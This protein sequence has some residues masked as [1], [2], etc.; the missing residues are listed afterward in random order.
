MNLL[1]SFKVI[2]MWLSLSAICGQ[3]YAEQTKPNIVMLY[4]DDWAWNGS[5]V[6]M[7]DAMENS[8]MPVLQMPNVEKLAREGMKFS[9]AYGSPQCAPAR[10][11]LQTGQSAA[12]NGFTVVLGKIKDDYYDM[13]KTYNYM[14]MIPNVAATAL[15]TNSMTI[16]K[17]LKPLGYESAHI[18]KWHMYCDPG[19]AGYVLHDGDTNNNPG[20]T[21]TFNLKKGEKAPSRL[22][23]D[24]KDPKLMF[25]MTEKAIGF[26]EEQVQKKKPFYLQISHYA[27][28]EG[29][30]CLD[31]TRQKYVNH[32]VVQEYYKKMGTT[33][34]KVNRKQD[35]ANWL[36]MG[37]DMDGRIG[38]VLNKIKELGI[39]DNTYVIMVSDNGYR[40]SDVAREQKQPLHGHKWWVWEG[41][42]R[43]PMIIKG[44]GILGGSTF[45]A[46]V[47]N[48]DFLPTF[49]EWAGGS[50]QSLQNIDGISLAPYLAGKTPEVDFVNRNLYFHFP[51]YR[52]SMPHSAV[53]SGKHKVMHF[54][55]RPDIPM[56]FDLSV[57]PGEVS[58]IAKQ[59][60]ETHKKLFQ[61]MMSYTKE[62]GGKFPKENPNFNI[63][64]Y[65][66]DKEYKK[67]QMWG[68]FEGDRP[69]E[70]DEK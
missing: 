3:A 58:N 23:K 49:V 11:C 46:N 67:R 18:G 30:E 5:P 34:E 32:P 9:N 21:L 70:T 47:I 43:V 12:R 57:D 6:A 61:E 37:E 55:E 8:R 19:E 36:A 51:H 45:K 16:A 14:P 27:M 53:I 13:R 26:M 44:P 38:A 28:H 25:S 56:L 68:P 4:L 24:I 35:P 20:N 41:G 29:R 42:I 69:L 1:I 64:K 50:P 65:A 63:K 10:V 62:V 59:H 39:E 33:P 40:H 31:S 7:N 60:P 52:G 15:D 17:A 22:P 54:Y 2:I 66:S 48:Y